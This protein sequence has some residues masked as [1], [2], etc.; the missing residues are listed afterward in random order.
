MTSGLL[1]NDDIFWISFHG[2]YDFAYLLRVSTNLFLPE[3]EGVFFE[4]LRIYFPHYYDIRYLVRYTENFRG[5]LS[6][7]GQELNI[8]RIGTQHQAGSDSLITCEIFNKLR[9]EYISSDVLLGDKNVL[10]GIGVGED[11]EFSSYYNSQSSYNVQNSNNAFGGYEYTT[12]VY[13]HGFINNAYPMMRNFGF[14]QGVGAGMYPMNSYSQVLE[15]N[16]KK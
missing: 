15:A 7:L 11:N 3:N 1:L 5:S 12:N 9:L 13:Q 10:F 2:I 4:T 6:K 14:Y 8:N 16:K